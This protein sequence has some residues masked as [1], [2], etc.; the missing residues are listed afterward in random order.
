[1]KRRWRSSQDQKSEKSKET[2]LAKAI[3]KSGSWLFDD[4]H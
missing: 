1:M 4:F 3:T 2:N